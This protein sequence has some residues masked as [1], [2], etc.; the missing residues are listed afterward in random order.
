M[1]VSLGC[2]VT[3]CSGTVLVRT[4]SKVKLGKRAKKVLTLTRTARYS[5]KAGG[6]A[7]IRLTL[8]ADARAL[9]R[10][11]KTVSVRIV[12]KPAGGVRSRAG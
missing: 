10:R 8:S 7:T 5:V 12:I 9:L 4:A 6:R 3:S 2:T 1:G 11:S